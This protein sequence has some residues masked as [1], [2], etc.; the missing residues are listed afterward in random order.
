MKAMVLRYTDV[1]PGAGPN[2]MILLAEVVFVGSEAEIPGRV[3]S[4]AGALGNGLPIAM[5]INNLANYP[6]V[7]EDALIA[8]AAALGLPVLSRTDCLFPTYQ[9]GA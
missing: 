9:R 6:N 3:R 5:A 1:D 2:D 8:R 7:V 4:D